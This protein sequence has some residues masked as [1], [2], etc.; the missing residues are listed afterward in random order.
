MSANMQKRILALN[1]ISCFGKCSLTVALP[2]ISSTGLECTILPNCVLSTH[3]AI[4]GFTLRD[5]TGEIPPIVD[6]W[7]RLGI[8]FDGIYT[9]FMCNK[10]Q[11]DIA[12]H[13]IDTL[14]GEG[15][16]VVVDPA[17][18]DN[19]KL[20]PIFDDTFP[21]YMRELCSKADII[22]P[23]ITEACMMLGKEY[24][25][26]PYTKD[27]VEGLLTELS[28]VGAKNII[29]TGVYFDDKKIGA[30]SYDCSTGETEYHLRDTVPGYYHGTGDVFCSAVVGAIGCG[31]TL[32]EATD[33][34]VD[35]T[36]DSIRR[37]YE[38]GTDVRFGV[39]FEDG[40]SAYA[41]RVR[42]ETLTRSK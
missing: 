20:Y 14:R 21:G 27:W 7:K 4:E 41:A 18:A 31:R 35:L 32:S 12:A 37:T 40:L 3:T 42:G 16:F 23:N 25:P 10:E 24:V 2:I 8:R 22:K 13:V 9:G 1:D 6:H 28:S 30:A 5:L 11:I 36:A 34:A 38:A 39:N 26:G 33:M 17:M 15:T 19:G 29:L